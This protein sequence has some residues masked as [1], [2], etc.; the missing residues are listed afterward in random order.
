[1]DNKNDFSDFMNSGNERPPT[2]LSESIF[3]MV[4]SDL[5]PQLSKIY[6][7]FLFVH[8]LASAISLSI[9]PQFGFR[10]FGEGHGLMKYFMNFGTYGCYVA[11]GS[12][13]IG[14]SYALMGVVLSKAEF[15]RIY[16]NRFAL[17]TSIVLISLGFFFMSGTDVLLGIAVSWVVGA[18]GFG[19]LT[20]ELFKKIN[21]IA[22]I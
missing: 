11:C 14:V 2:H 16:R 9:C 12:F 20:L 7:K 17:T 4:A 18:L 6:S 3:N 19:I 1:M 15:L 8:L 10:L 5:N 13:F 21:R 22:A